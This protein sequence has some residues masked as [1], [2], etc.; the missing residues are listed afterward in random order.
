MK[1]I[2]YFVLMLFTFVSITY[3]KEYTYN[4]CDTCEYSS[5]GALSHDYYTITDSL[6]DGDII[7]VYLKSGEYK[8]TDYL[9]FYTY[10]KKNIKLI[11]N[12]E[13]VDKTTISLSA[14]INFEKEDVEIHN[15][16]IITD[17][18]LYFR[19]P[20]I[21]LENLKISSNTT[22]PQVRLIEVIVDCGYKYLPGKITI[23]NVD[24]TISSTDSAAFYYNVYH[25][26]GHEITINNSNLNADYSIYYESYEKE[27]AG[28]GCYNND[29]SRFDV[30]TLA[31]QIYVSNSELNKVYAYREK[32]D[33][34]IGV[35]LA[36]TNKMNLGTDRENVLIEEE[37]GKIVYEIID[38][39]NMKLTENLN[40]QILNIFSQNN[41]I[42]DYNNANVTIQYNDIVNYE[43]NTF[44]ALKV[45]STAVN[46]KNNNTLYTITINITDGNVEGKDYQNPNTKDIS[47]FL[48][49]FFII[50]IVTISIALKKLK[51]PKNI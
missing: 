6:N 48:F 42:L 12:G 46:I 30:G 37:N 21:T 14:V 50:S 33:N 35:L 32:D 41:D 40:S 15:L 39:I 1:K 38:E 51:Y 13:G 2:I 26:T 25:G 22:D 27:N 49:I 18:F 36:S 23:N 5:L 34:Q 44:T 29:D 19:S 11:I 45:G 43:N 20:N 47:L 31:E 16:Q 28:C 8:E 10:S 3:A 7:N 4:I 24:A 17:A 9:S